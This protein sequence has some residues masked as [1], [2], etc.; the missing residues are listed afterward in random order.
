[1]NLLLDEQLD[2]AVADAL[3]AF[4]YRHGCIYRSIRGLASGLKDE[5]I[6]EFCKN[7]GIEALVTANVRDFGAKLGLYQALLDA[8]ISV[9]VVRPSGKQA[10]TPEVQLSILSGQSIV[11]ARRLTKSKGPLLLRVTQ[12]GVVARTLGQLRA[13]IAGKRLP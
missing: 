11:I 3:N 5:D 6:P 10:L 2:T 4:Q 13:E 1:M 9:V 7:Q 8:D 12:G